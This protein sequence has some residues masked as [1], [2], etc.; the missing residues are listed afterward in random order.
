MP[1]T[2]EPKDTDRQE[3]L[4]AA[5]TWLRAQRDTHGWTGSDLAR[6]LGINQ[7][8]VSAYERGQ[9]EVPNEIADKLAEVLDLSVIEVRRE[10]GLWVPTDAE[11][12]HLRYQPDPRRMTDDS[13]IGELV[14]RYQRRTDRELIDV[15]PH[16]SQVPT[17]LWDRLLLGARSE[18]LLGG[19]TNYFF[20]TERP[21]FRQTLIDKA[22][23]GVRIRFLVG[24]PH[25]DVTQ[26]RERIEQA[27]L[28]LTTRIR[29]TLDELANIAELPGLEIRLSDVNAEAHVSRSVFRFD[30]EALVC[31]HIADKLGHG[32]LTL[33][34]RRRQDDGPFDQY[35]AHVQY[36]WDGAR[37]WQ[38]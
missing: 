7:V 27:A 29:I 33:Y 24:D 15:F 19:Y 5:G 8:R 20:W 26:R 35:S 25:N 30:R 18:I 22:N 3:R 37:P 17:E 2:D 23:A 1:A 34:L 9:Y 28:A 4:R 38:P 12:Q 13:L 14:R 32:S 36:L 31:E 6:H 11:I 10:L 16:R 21:R